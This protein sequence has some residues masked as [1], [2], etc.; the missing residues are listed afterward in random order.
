[1]H[2]KARPSV[3]LAVIL[4]ALPACDNVEWEGIDLRLAA[5]SDTSIW[6]A[7]EGEDEEAAPEAMDLGPVL[8]KVERSA[9]GGRAIPVARITDDGFAPLPDQDEAPDMP[10][11]FRNDLLAPGAE[12]VLLLE[13]RRAGTF[14]VFEEGEP[15]TSYCLPR[16]TAT[17]A[18][19]VAQW[20]DG[21]ETFLAVAKDPE[22]PVLHD[23]TRSTTELPGD[24]AVVSVDLA[25]RV[26]SMSE[27][28]WPP[29]VPDIVRDVRVASF[30]RAGAPFLAASLVQDDEL[31]PGEAPGSA[32][33]IFYMASPVPAEDG[34]RIH[35]FW[36]QR[37]DGGGK[38]WPRL[39][40]ALDGPP[41]APD[42]ILLELVGE[43]DRSFAVV[44]GEGGDWSFLLTEP[45]ASH[46]EVDI[47][48][49]EWQE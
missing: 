26:L 32:Y 11:R 48:G 44:A 13:G 43:G 6:S 34:Y 9:S 5:P 20:A 30:P 25:N 23:P 21:A 35:W 4:I 29:S 10:E 3:A 33:S 46:D 37:A 41:S 27:A 39:I 38:A 2:W 7:P 49:S 15:E 19:E 24:P 16:P 1:M 14:V 45:C 40:G 8:Y 18:V 22:A 47:T 28:P 31:A 36:Y 42:A 12:L 17:G